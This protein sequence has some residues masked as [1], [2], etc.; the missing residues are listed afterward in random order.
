MTKYI[1]NDACPAA[2][3]GESQSE[4]SDELAALWISNGNT[5][6]S[7]EPWPGLPFVQS[8]FVETT[9]AVPD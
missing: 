9:G 5:K 1:H 4:I 8:Y 3:F 7:D 2:G 6:I